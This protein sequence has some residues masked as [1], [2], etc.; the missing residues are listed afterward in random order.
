[1][2]PHPPLHVEPHA[3][4]ADALADLFLADGAMGIP[5][6][7]GPSLRLAPVASN[8]EPS[9][10]QITDEPGPS[11]TRL[12]GLVLGHLPVQGSTWIVPYAKFVADAERRPVALVRLHG[13]Q[14]WVDLVLPRGAAP[15]SNSRIGQQPHATDLAGAI[16]QASREAGAW[17]LRVEDL[18]EPGLLNLRG[19]STVTLLTGSDEAAVVAC[20]RTIKTLFEDLPREDAPE[21]RVAIM[22]G[23]ASK[24]SDAEAR[25]SKAAKAFL[26]KPLPPAA[27]VGQVGGGTTVS[28]YRGPSVP[29]AEI[30]ELA[31][32]AEVRSS[33]E[34]PPTRSRDTSPPGPFT[35]A[36]VVEVPPALPGLRPLEIR[37][38]YA[39]GVV[40]CSGE[41]GSLHL[42][43]SGT[44]RAGHFVQE[45]LAA[46][47]WADDHAALLEA[48]SAGALRAIG[49]SGPVLHLVV[50]DAKGARALIDTGVRLHLAL[51]VDGKHVFADLN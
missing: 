1:M 26:G 22:G 28:L 6:Q 19:V 50:S 15:R 4:D 11:S 13:G 31:L 18:A 20:Y 2:R 38:P 43:A 39:P 36:P 7:A 27:I 30:V 17:L 16:R 34:P 41:G 47:S 25:I 42:V 14:T 49:A 45:L 48:A 24:A 51:A 32:R 23:D 29:P 10:A 35:E 40:I 8:A 44:T 9:R 5:A 33:A 37:C 21:V 12:E 46:A 3:A